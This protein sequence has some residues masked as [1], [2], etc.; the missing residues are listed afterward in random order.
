VVGKAL[1]HEEQ[2]SD[3]LSE[4]AR[5]MV[6]DFPIQGILDHLVLRI[7]D[8]MP[9]TAA[10]VTLIS[11]GNNPQY[12][13][14]SNDAALRFEKLQTE[15]G[16][17]PCLAA[18]ET[19]EAVSVPDLREERRFPKFAP[20]ALDAGLAAVFTFPL[21]NG[22]ARLGALD[23]YRDTPGPLSVEAMTAAQTLADV[24]AAYLIN[25]QARADL[26]DSSDQSRES[27]LHDALT[28]LPNRILLL[29][30]LHHSLLRGRR[31]GSIA[32]VL[33]ADL[34]QFKVVNDMYS[35][36]VGDELLV[37]VAERLTSQLRPGDTLARLSGDEFVLL[38]EDLAEAAQVDV[39]AARVGAAIGKPFALSIGE[40]HTTASIGIAFSGRADHIP[41]DLLHTADLAMYQAKRKGGSRHQIIDLGEQR[42]VEHQASLVRDIRSAC[43]NGQLLMEYQPIVSTVDGR[44]IGVEAL[45]RWAHPSFGLISPATLIPLAEQSGVIVEIGRWVLEQSCEAVL[46]WRDHYQTDD[47]I[48]SVNVSAAQLMSPGFTEMVKDVLFSTLTDPKLLTLE[49]TESIFVQDS[50]RALVVLNELK[51]IGVMLAL[52]D[53]GTGYSSLSYLKGFP[54]DTLKI[55]PEFVADLGTDRSSKAIVSAVV[56]LA[57]ILG[58]TVVAEGVETAAQR[59]D[60][61]ALGCDACQGFYFARPM[62]AD[63]LDALMSHGVAGGSPRLPVLAAAS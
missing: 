46:R 19:G 60:V 32:A 12:L 39:I 10:G 45:L 17:G 57:H 2:L 4:F 15:L 41:E 26:Q 36:R 42:L 37:A 63:D 53:F 54:V 40:V 48:M 20:R 28:G 50:K 34:D 18:Y 30:R 7:V 8:I 14:A 49:V 5:T 47:L 62:P 58:L 33:F 3:V 51:S 23:L 27:S 6:T 16:E 9:I 1:P 44:V 52:D 38:C 25:A 35:H 13:A 31:S 11:P 21:R 56:D 29:E 43:S 22:D 59:N 61:A 55:D 24:V